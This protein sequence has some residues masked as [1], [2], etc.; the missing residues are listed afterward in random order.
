[1][2][3]DFSIISARIAAYLAATTLGSAFATQCYAQARVSAIEGLTACR[4]ISDPN[5]RLAC[6]DAAAGALIEAV[7]AGALTIVD[8]QQ[9]QEVRRNLFGFSSTAMPSFLGPSEVGEELSAIQTSLMRATRG[10]GGRWVFQ[11]SDGSEWRQVD[12]E[13]AHIRPQSGDE[14]R[15]RRAAFG[16][17]FLNVGDARAIR[18]KR[19]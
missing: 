16:S 1:M 14:V 5:A 8:R 9:V 15:V 6:L 4:P 13:P 11:L 7:D 17:Y 10:D 19:Q 3:R 18:V 12:N 2:F